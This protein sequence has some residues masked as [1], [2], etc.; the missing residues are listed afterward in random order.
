MTADQVKQLTFS[1]NLFGIGEHMERR[2][3]EALSQSLHP[4]EF[5]RLVLEDEQL[6]RKDRQANRLITRARFRSCVDI[7]D[8]DQTYDRGV[9]K[10]KLKE[11][12]SMGFYPQRENLILLGK[13]GCGKT[14]LA[15][16]LGRRACLSGISVR[17]LPIN[18]LFEEIASE[19]AAGRYLLYL[20]PLA[21]IGILILDDFGLRNYSH[22]E[23]TL[24]LDLLEERYQ[25]GSLIVTSQVDPK[26][27]LKLFEDPV[28]AEA[29]VD[30]M[31]HPSQK[32]PLLGPSYRERLATKKAKS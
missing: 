17:F 24:L 31:K 21:K 13:T 32:I 15:I 2:A 14:H 4:L 27:W 5:L 18:V 6:S 12:S 11:L 3:Q 22:E 1:M 20:K 28:I 16:A 19:K 10:V 7:E 29:I 8:W 25:K 23:A 9:S 30:R 26:G